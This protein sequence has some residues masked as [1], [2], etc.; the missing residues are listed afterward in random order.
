MGDRSHGVLVRSRFTEV[1]RVTLPPRCQMWP[2]RRQ[3]CF[4]IVKE[5]AESRRSQNDSVASGSPAV[6]WGELEDG[7]E[8]VLKLAWPATNELG[9]LWMEALG[10]RMQCPRRPLPPSQIVAALPR[11][12][13]RE[14]PPG[15]VS[16]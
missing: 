10:K 8:H 9:E 12:S 6:L 11:P 2:H 14:A 3:V 7:Q 4:R 1:G 16:W 15:V 5:H 13:A